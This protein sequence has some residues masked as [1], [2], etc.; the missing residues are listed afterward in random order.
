MHCLANV[1]LHLFSLVDCTLY[2]VASKKTKFSRTIGFYLKLLIE[3]RRKKT[4]FFYILQRKS[5][6]QLRLILVC[7]DAQ[8]YLWKTFRQKLYYLKIATTMI[9]LHCKSI[10]S[11]VKL[12]LIFPSPL[13]YAVEEKNIQALSFSLLNVEPSWGVSNRHVYVE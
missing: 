11:C 9:L 8:L 10:F 3:T 1:H 4:E 2:K 6:L 7:I 13:H 5:L 12:L